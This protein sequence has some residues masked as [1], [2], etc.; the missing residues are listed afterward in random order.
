MDQ[1]QEYK[2]MKG[3]ELK[4]LCEQQGLATSG[5]KEILLKRLMGGK[6][7]NSS[8]GGGSQSKKAKADGEEFGPG[9]L[10][11]VARW[12]Q[13]NMATL[14]SLCKERGLKL[15]G[16]KAH[17]LVRLYTGKKQ[18][19]DE[20]EDIGKE[21]FGKN[22]AL[23]DY[24]TKVAENEL[25]FKGNILRQVAALCHHYPFVIKSGKDAAK[26]KGIGKSS[27]QKIQE[28]LD[29]KEVTPTALVPLATIVSSNKEP[30]TEEVKED[31]Q[32]KTAETVNNGSEQQPI[33]EKTE[34]LS[35]E[36]KLLE[37]LREEESEDGVTA[38]GV[39]LQIS[40]SNSGEIK[41]LLTKLCEEGQLYTTIDENHFKFAG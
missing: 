37:I 25:N 33:D 10:E 1:L 35:L 28:I 8:D 34:Q 13:D 18:S 27:A 2:K 22:P 4:A 36:N 40:G 9:T 21:I 32:I 39:S 20:E 19:V 7:K 3:S 6:R 29:G 12:A 23:T 17:L 5:S 16:K 15:S 30:T 11:D 26:L 24:F 14:K 41:E 31:K 38:E